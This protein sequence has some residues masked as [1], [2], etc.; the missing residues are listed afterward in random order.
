MVPRTPSLDELFRQVKAR[1]FAFPRYES[2]RG[3]L[4][5][6]LRMTIEVSEASRT[7]VYRRSGTDDFVHVANYALLAR[8]LAEQ[9]AF[10]TDAPIGLRSGSRARASSASGATVNPRINVFLS[11]R[12]SASSRT[13]TS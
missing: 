3:F 1:A 4:E 10:A 6:L 11:N 9:G 2:A 13:S 8:R 5:D 7:I 12:T